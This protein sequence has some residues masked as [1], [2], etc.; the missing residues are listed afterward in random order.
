MYFKNMDS[1]IPFA[2]LHRKFEALHCQVSHGSVLTAYCPPPRI[3]FPQMQIK[4]V[5]DGH[6]ITFILL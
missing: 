5:P 1:W 6:Q 3:T 4:K 2:N